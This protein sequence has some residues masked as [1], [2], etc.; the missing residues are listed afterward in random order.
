MPCAGAGLVVGWGARFGR[1]ATRVGLALGALLA[2]AGVGATGVGWAPGVVCAKAGA[3][4][5]TSHAGQ[6][7]V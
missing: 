3:M 7:R 6:T 5:S 2:C 1:G 4:L